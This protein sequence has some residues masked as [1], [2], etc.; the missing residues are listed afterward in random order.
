MPDFRALIESGAAHLLDGA[1]GTEL[2]QRGVFI[3]VCYDELNLK[4]PEI[5]REVHRAYLDAGAEILET[6]TF[7]GNRERLS[8]FGLGEEVADVNR[9]GAEL[10][11]AEAGDDAYVVGSLGPLG[12]R[13][14]PYGPTSLDTE[15]TTPRWPTVCAS[16]GPH[17]GRCPRSE[18]ESRAGPAP[19]RRWRNMCRSLRP[20]SVPP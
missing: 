13:I 1:L 18:P 2:Y 19:P 5:V 15:M 16:C 9:A 20:E 10:A 6:N 4:R 14:E 11:R 17:P 3:N 7:G 8:R 12:I